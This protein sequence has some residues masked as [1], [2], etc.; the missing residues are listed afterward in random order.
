MAYLPPAQR[1]LDVLVPVVVYRQIGRRPSEIYVDDAMTA[2]THGEKTKHRLSDRVYWRT[3]AN[4]GDQIQYRPGGVLLL[5][6]KGECH[7]VTLVEPTPLT[8]ATAFTHADLAIK[9]DQSE[10]DRLI[11]TG[12]LK[13]G[14]PRRSK[15]P[16]SRPADKVFEVDHPLVVDELPRG[17]T[18]VADPRQNGRAGGN[19]RRNPRAPSR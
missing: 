11:G 8:A 15:L 3:R 2:A 4:P 13:E 17:V 6:A 19:W 16:P 5:T 1:A 7:P 18:L 9:A 12:S 14:T 10:A